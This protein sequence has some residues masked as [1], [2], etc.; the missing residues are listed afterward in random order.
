[1]KVRPMKLKLKGQLMVSHAA[2]LIIFSLIVGFI[3]IGL[4]SRLS[5]T[6]YQSEMEERA[7]AIATSMSSF[8]AQMSSAGDAGEAMGKGE[9]YGESFGK[10]SYYMRFIDDAA[11]ANAWIVNADG[12]IYTTDASAA[13]ETADMPD[14]ARALISQVFETNALCSSADSAY[15]QTSAIT[16][17][18]P[19]QNADG[20]P[21]AAV[22]LSTQS[23]LATDTA[24]SGL[25]ILGA[26]MIIALVLTILL[27]SVMAR[28]F[29]VPLKR[30]EETTKRLADGDYAAQTGIARGDEIGSLAAHVDQ[31]AARLDEAS[32]E[33]E[34]LE[35]LRREFIANI[36]HELRT[37]VTVMRGS[38]EALR[39]GV[40]SDPQQVKDYY[41]QLVGESIHLE[42]MVN[43]L[44]E[45]TRLQNVDYRI[46][47]APLNLPNVLDDALRA[48]RQLAMKKDVRFTIDRRITAFPFNG[49]Y[50]RLRQLFIIVLDNAVKFSPAGGTIDV[51]SATDTASGDARIAITDHGPGIPADQLPRIFERFYKSGDAANA[52][53]SGLGL[54]IAGQ[55]AQRHGVTLTADSTEGDHTTFTFVFP[56]GTADPQAL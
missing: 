30:M 31:L 16:V 49:D 2:V 29:T 6:I 46:E 53:G 55:I 7:Q 23:G 4:F 28:H 44:L 52:S 33:S 37:P 48:C 27:S 32:K 11:G 36:S 9:H 25:K 54:A 21:V 38:L 41:Q 43:D 17:G 5:V 34:K 42:R 45:L 50:G 40:I 18:A 35:K 19:V 22:I 8:V 26:S 13:P 10:H 24:L 20:T 1:M 56:A 14:A 39:D 3:F 51:T 47:K 12:T 15:G